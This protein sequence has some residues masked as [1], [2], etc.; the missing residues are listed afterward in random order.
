MAGFVVSPGDDYD[1]ISVALDTANTDLRI[2]ATGKSLAVLEITGELDVRVGKIENPTIELDKVEG[3]LSEATPFE[4]LFF[5]NAGQ[6]GKI[7]TLLI[8]RV[9]GLAVKRV[10]T[11]VNLS[12]VGGT[13]QTGRNITPDLAKL[14][15]LSPVE[16]AN[17]HNTAQPA[18]E[19]SL[20]GADI[21]P[22]NTPALFRVMVSMSNA[23]I[24]RAAVTK[25]GNTQAVDCNS[26]GALVA[27]ALYIFDVLVHNG[28]TMNFR[29]SV[30][31]GTTKVLRV[32]EI[33]AGAQ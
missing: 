13:A 30:T 33:P 6:A 26:G 28:D 17:V 12:K 32:Q 15:L 22:T 10:Q 31:G 21:A 24:F 8:S 2:E 1:V 4:T 14:Q 9:T 16:K 27:S 5:T 29:Y 11:D 3:V 25:A 18:A 20:L 19:A 23:G 7:A